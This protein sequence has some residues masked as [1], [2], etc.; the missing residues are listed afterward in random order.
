MVE[1]AAFVMQV[2]EG[3][4]EEYVALHEARQTTRIADA[5]RRAGIRN[6]SGWL[7]GKEGRQV[8]AYLAA[9]GFAASVERLSGDPINTEWQRAV[10][11]LMDVTGGFE[12]RDGLVLL[13]PVFYRLYATNWGERARIVV[14]G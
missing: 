8:F 1:R 4:V 2:K 11:P 10:S 14:A 5:R 3:R 6:Y 7:G 13:R 12:S 9:D